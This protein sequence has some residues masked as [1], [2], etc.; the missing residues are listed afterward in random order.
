MRQLVIA[1][2][3]ATFFCGAAGSRAQADD[4]CDTS[5]AV[6]CITL[7]ADT[8]PSPGS[9]SSAAPISANAA[10]QGQA[11]SVAVPPCQV[12]GCC[13]G[14][15]VYA[16]GDPAISAAPNISVVAPAPINCRPY[17]CG[18]LP[19]PALGAPTNAPSVAVPVP[20]P[21]PAPVPL[22]CSP[23]RSIYST[24]NFANAADVR[25]LRTL[26]TDGLNA[27][28]RQGALNQIQSQVTQ[29]AFSGVYASTRLY[30][31]QV[32]DSSFSATSRTATVHTIEHWLYQQRSLDD[33]SVIFSQDQWVAN[34]Y[35]LSF[36]GNTW[37]ITTNIATLTS[38][39]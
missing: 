3:V 27:Y 8:S 28:W 6:A 36:L 23:Y 1:I 32:Q 33:G 39:P 30:S 19:L 22:N 10:G 12:N 38:A 2:I 16:T 18:P 37:Y 15:G 35:D 26:S 29:L 11:A 25:A 24:I 21:V 13:Y 9:T 20:A 14:G 17:W 31:I 7:P 4:G 34:E 5:E